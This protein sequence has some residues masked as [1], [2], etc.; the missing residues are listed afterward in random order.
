MGWRYRTCSENRGTHPLEEPEG[1]RKT[2]GGAQ[3]LE[4]G[5]L[6]YCQINGC[7]WK[8]IWGDSGKPL[9]ITEQGVDPVPGATG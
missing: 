2:W 9:K 6:Q 1:A 8:F 5:V 7:D 3:E 4:E